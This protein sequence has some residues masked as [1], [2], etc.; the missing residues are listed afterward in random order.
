MVANLAMGR[1]DLHMHTNASDGKPAVGALLNFVRDQRPHLTAIAIT[2]HDTL[3]ST[4]WA[5]ESAHLYPF[6]VIPGVEVSSRDGHVLALWVTT[7][8]PAHMNLADTVS[9][10]HE[11]G[12]LA[13]LAHPFHFFLQTHFKAALRHWQ[14]PEVLLQANIDA[15]EGHNA[16]VGGWGCNALAQNVARK[17]GVSLV[18]GSDA[19]TLGAI[20]S[21]TTRYPGRSAIDLRHALITGTTIA[22]GRLWPIK[23]YVAY[24]KNERQR[25]GMMSSVTTTSSA[26]INP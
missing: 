25:K 18:A 17:I 5:Y 6:D 11:A 3:D 9:A 23:E 12:G 22:E 8:I 10:I 16:G 19:H 15:I 2:D 21:S 7:P 13:V 14:R 26:P 1:A 4:L 24:F 20:G